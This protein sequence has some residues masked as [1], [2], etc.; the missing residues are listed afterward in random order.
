MLFSKG[1][2]HSFHNHLS[3]RFLY[4]CLTAAHAAL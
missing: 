1:I 2:A 3:P 4:F